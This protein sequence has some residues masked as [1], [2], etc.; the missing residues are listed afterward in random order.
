M[1][2]VQLIRLMGNAG[3]NI[4]YLNVNLYVHIPLKKHSLSELRKPKLNQITFLAN[5][6]EVIQGT[7]K[8]NQDVTNSPV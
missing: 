1:F 4:F 2:K 8:K 6:D 3:K 7:F 5:R